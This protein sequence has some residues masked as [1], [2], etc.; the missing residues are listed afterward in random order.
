MLKKLSTQI[1]T[2]PKIF[3]GKQFLIDHMMVVHDGIIDKILPQNALNT[4][5]SE[6]RNAQTIAFKTGIL[7]AGFI[8]IQ[9]N[10]GGGILL[11]NSPSIEGLKTMLAAHRKFG[12]TSML[13]TFISDSF[14]NMQNIINVANDALKIQL[15]GMLGLHLEG[16]YFN[17]QQKGVHSPLQIRPVD[18]D[19]KALFCN[20]KNGILMVTLAPEKVPNGFIKSLRDLGLLVYAG[21]TNATY[22]QIQLAINEGLS[23][24]THL[25]N[26]MS[27]LTSREPGVVGASI[28]DE[29]TFFGIIL[30]KKHVSDTSAKIAIRAKK[31]GKACLITDSMSPVGTTDNSFELYGQTISVK[32]GY[33]ITK[34][35]TLAGSALDMA[36]AVRN[37]IQLD[38]PLEEA[39]RMASAYPTAALN[40]AHKIGS[41]KPGYQADI[42][43]LNNNLLVTQSAIKGQW[44]TSTNQF[45]SLSPELQLT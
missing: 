8:D 17:L 33:C 38:I 1:I 41:L 19:A 5:Q 4:Y 24:F 10:G 29:N 15:D 40:M 44:Q 18:K 28:E 43:H 42:I 37:C 25:Y 45:N 11:N 3:D 32:D 22:D 30:D 12:T 13:P 6:Y 39:L 9:V 27:P 26:A 16:P 20:L 35:G 36:T 2:A 7:T 23:G 34:E 21:H 31:Q 14:D